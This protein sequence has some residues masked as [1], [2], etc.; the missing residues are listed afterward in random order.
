MRKDRWKLVF[1][2]SYGSYHALPGNDGK[3]GKRVRTSVDSLE[4]YD[5]SRDPGEEYNVIELYPDIVDELQ[6]VAT[7]ARQ[8]LGDLN[9]GI[10]SGAGSRP[11][12]KL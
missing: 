8:E 10:E 2:H 7:R 3:G 6:E 5:M 4:L 12:G 11:V 1:P 9:Q